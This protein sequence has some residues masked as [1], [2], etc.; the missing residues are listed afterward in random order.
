MPN[1]LMPSNASNNVNIFFHDHKIHQDTI[2]DRVQ[3]NLHMFSFLQAGKKQVH[4]SDETIEVNHQQSLLIKSGNCIWTELPNSHQVYYCK[5]L[6]FSTQ[7]LN[8]F[9]SKHVKNSVAQP[10]ELPPYF[11]IENDRY[12]QTFVESL[13]S[14]KHLNTQLNEG[15]MI[16]KFEE[17]MLYLLHKYGGGFVQYIQTLAN[18]PKKTTFQQ[19]VEAHA[20]AD[21]TLEEV[22]FLCHMSLSTFKRRFVKEYGINPGKWFQ[23]KKLLQAKEILESQHMSPSDVY[24]KAGYKNLS[25]FSFAFK[26]EFGVT[27]GQVF[28]QAS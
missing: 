7:Q 22:A 9:I 13:A 8:A 25:N 5:L 19:I 4:F 6:F 27:P 15:V 17:I 24:L 14:L 28:K 21:L 1:A 18:I 2:K 10:T 3:L 26:K 20:Y 12:I 23:K 16:I 11:I